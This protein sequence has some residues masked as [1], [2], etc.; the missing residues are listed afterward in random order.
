MEFTPRFFSNNFLWVI[1]YRPL[2]TST[3]NRFSSWWHAKLNQKLILFERTILYGWHQKSNLWEVLNYS[4]IVAKYQIF[5][6]SVPNGTLVFECFLL[7]LNNKIAIRCTIA[8]ETNRVD[9]LTKSWA[10]LLFVLFRFFFFFRL[11]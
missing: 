4:L 10:K 2:F 6:T 1:F 8:V 9:T 7:R 3:V 11:V 5:A